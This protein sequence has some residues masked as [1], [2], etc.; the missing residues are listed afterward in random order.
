MI[1]NVDFALKLSNYTLFKRFFM[2]QMNPKDF[3]HNT[4][5]LI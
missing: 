3:L 1:F 5:F 2:S 4:T